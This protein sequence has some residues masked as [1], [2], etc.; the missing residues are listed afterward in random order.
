M[1]LAPPEREEPE[2]IG[3]LLVRNAQGLRMPLRE[4]ADVYLSA[5]RYAIL[6]DGAR[7]RQTVTCNPS[8]RDVASFVGGAKKGIEAKGKCAARVYPD[9][10]G[11]AEGREEADGDR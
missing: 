2:S 11:G 4:L 5:G 9:Y 7:R 1:V 6:H 8:G 3:G 10:S